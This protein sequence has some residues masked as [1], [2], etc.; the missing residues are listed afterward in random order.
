MK[1]MPTYRAKTVVE[2]S[3][4]KKRWVEIGVGFKNKDTIKI[5][6]DA[7]PVNGEIIL[8]PID[9]SPQY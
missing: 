3:E 9:E 7:L 4:G 2:I 1:N 8:I 6:L 5:R